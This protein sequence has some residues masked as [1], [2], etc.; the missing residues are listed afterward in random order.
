MDSLYDKLL[1]A[2]VE[3]GPLI[4]DLCIC[5]QCGVSQFVVVPVERGFEG[6]LCPECGKPGLDQVE[7]EP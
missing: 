2:C 5:R 4:M 3:Y 7:V 1:D 6:G